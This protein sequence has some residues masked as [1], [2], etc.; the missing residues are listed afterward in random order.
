[1]NNIL[2]NEQMLLI[3]II[4]AWIFTYYLN[5]NNFLKKYLK[6]TSNRKEAFKEK[7]RLLKNKL[8]ILE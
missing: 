5:I 6:E 1:M 2:T 8:I 7:D 4:L 3:F